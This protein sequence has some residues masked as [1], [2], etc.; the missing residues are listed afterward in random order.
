MTTPAI[1]HARSLTRIADHLALLAPTT[2]VTQQQL[3]RAIRV[4]GV[5]TEDKTTVT[6]LLPPL[7]DAPTVGVYVGWLRQTARGLP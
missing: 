5:T 3:D 7:T 1:A 2:A 4:A 6:E